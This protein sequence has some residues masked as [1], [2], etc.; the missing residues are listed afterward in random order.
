MK[1]IAEKFTELKTSIAGN[2]EK[3]QYEDTFGMPKEE[4]WYVTMPGRANR[5]IIS[6]LEFAMHLSEEKEGCFDGLLHQALDYLLECRARQGVLTDDVCSAAENL[7]APMEA[8]AKAYQLILAGHA[9]IDMNWM[10][11]FNETV[12]ATLATFRS[13]LNVMDEYPDFCFSQSQ[14][15]VYKIVEEYDPGL[16]EEIKERIAEGRWEVTASAWVEAD[17]NMPTGESLLRH[18]QYTREYLSEVWGVKDFDLDFSPDTFGHSAN[19]PEIDNFGGVK[20]FY[21]CRGNARKDVLYLYEA[22]SGAQL[23]SYREPNWYNGAITPQIGAGL[24]EISRR[25]ADL[26]T[27]LVV[28]GVGNHGGGPTRRDVERAIEMKSWRIYP[29]IRFGT[30]REYFRAA[31]EVRGKL[32]VVRQELNYFAPGCYTTQ[33]RIKRGNRRLESALLDAE[34]MAALAGRKA[35]FSYDRKRFVKAWQDVLFTHFHDILTGSCVQD[36]REHAMGLFQTSMAAANT[37]LQNAMR[38][39]GMQIDTSSIAVDVDAYNSQ[40]EGAGAG[41]GIENFIG[42][43]S[44]ERGSG[45]TRIFHIFNTSPNARQE[46]VELTVWDWTGDL[47]RL[48]VRDYKGN[49]LPF[50]VLD[51]T[52]QQYWDHK[53]IRVLVDAS[54]PA[55]GY[56]TVVL[57]QREAEAY[58]VYLQEREQVAAAYDDYDLENELLRVRICAKTGRILS[59]WSKESE[60]EL[61]DAGQSAGLQF[62]ETE[63][64]TSSAWNIGRTIRSMPADRCLKLE[65]ITEGPLRDSVKATLQMAAS[66]AEITYVLEKGQPCVR[67]ELKVDWNESGGDTIPVL[68]YQV[69]LS[70][71]ANAFRYDIPAGSIVREGIRNDVPAL[72][73][74]MAVREEGSSVVLI[75]DSKYG[76]R[77][78][79][80]SLSLSLINSSTSPDPYPERG[81]HTITLWL[82]A[83]DGDAGRTEQLATYCNHRMFYQPSNCHTGTLPMEDSLLSIEPG[84]AVISAVLP[85][86]DG[87]ITVRGYEAAGKRTEVEIC[88][89]EAPCSASAVDLHGMP[90]E[91]D[92]QMQGNKVNAKVGPYSIFEVKIGQ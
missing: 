89:K 86:T 79:K 74:G 84:S 47:R 61:L 52:M 1:T 36:S 92:V 73:Y 41:Y 80:Q 32:P 88:L 4:Q 24:I 6:E 28:Y 16:M 55:L 35:G 19:I 67:M 45:R 26:K 39:I 13:V 22:P 33:S 51:R 9:H 42:V 59:L 29:S 23:L 63:C 34:A 11:S 64:K 17:K 58:P 87:G 30:L 78:D 31:E 20:Y 3:T 18:I 66:T 62:L 43:P 48:A 75:S 60:E 83:S 54:V 91:G 10:W 65:R 7:L 53:Y 71:R 72:Q 77:G 21:H 85:D 27:G 44:T 38:A 50:Q 25:S 2:R 81:I 46:A 37:Q 56:T 68:A 8:E 15:A 76:Y 90:A 57:F 70:Y 69:P 14:A 40:S 82:G 12:A 49:E 5:R